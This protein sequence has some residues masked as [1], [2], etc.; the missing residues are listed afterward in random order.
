MPSSRALQHTTRAGYFIVGT[1]ISIWGTLVPYAKLRLGVNDAV[2]GLLLLC[3][4][5]GSLLTMPFAGA[6]AGRFGCRRIILLAGTVLLLSLPLLATVSSVVPFALSLLLL[7]AAAGV[8]EVALTIQAVFVEQAA[9]RAMMPG[10]HSLYSFGGLFGAGVMSLLL[11]VLSPAQA[12]AGLCACLFV[13]LAVAGPSFLPGGGG[14]EPSALFALPRGIVL[15]IGLGCFVLY[16]AEGAI[17]DWGALFMATERGAETA[18]AGLAFACFS[19]A[20]T[21]GRLTG[22]RI[23]Q[24]FGDTRVLL[25]GSLVAAAGFAMVVALPWIPASLAGFA[26]VGLGL[27]NTVPVLYSALARQKIMPLRLAVSAV[28][29]IGYLGVLAGPALMGFVA[30]AT[31]LG[32]VFAVTLGMMCFVALLSRFIR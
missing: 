19:V 30:H 14:G 26:V 16:L 31:R 15:L 22:N 10:F 27:S 24:L 29:T 12:A 23:V 25:C 9:G 11:G 21:V 1:G 18:R 6:V 13:L 5:V 2:L 20:M 3:V 8:L 4:G 32:M 7:G 17:L 28:T